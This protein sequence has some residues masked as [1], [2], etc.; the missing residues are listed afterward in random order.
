[1]ADDRHAEGHIH[2]DSVKALGATSAEE[3]KDT[4]DGTRLHPLEYR[5]DVDIRRASTHGPVLRLA[6]CMSNRR[7]AENSICAT[8][9]TVMNRPERR[10]A[11]ARDYCAYRACPRVRRL[12]AIAGH[13][14]ATTRLTLIYEDGRTDRVDAVERRRRVPASLDGRGYRRILT[15]G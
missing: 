15:D 4:W 13:S 9:S 11:S 6:L 1:M 2:D 10:F 7:Q 8:Q 5:R 3:R 14:T 12:V